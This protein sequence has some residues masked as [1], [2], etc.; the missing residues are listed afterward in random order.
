[1]DKTKKVTKSAKAGQLTSSEQETVTTQQ[2]LD[3]GLQYHNAG[4]LPKA[5]HFYQQLLKSEPNHPEALHLLGVV[6]H[7]G[8]KNN[9]ALDLIMKALAIKPEF[10]EAQCNLGT[11]LQ[12]L[13][14][15]DD[16]LV[17]YRKAI[18]IKPDYA[19]GRIIELPL[20]F[21]CRMRGMIRS[22]N[23][24]DAILKGFLYS[25]NIRICT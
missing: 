24:N 8:G 9:T 11:I 15:L 4:D 23:I 19:K 21:I 7:Q 3:L 13:G 10:A 2:A 14:K 12:E 22:N 17:H 6:S 5:E 20:L 25:L 16:A 1:M 18:K